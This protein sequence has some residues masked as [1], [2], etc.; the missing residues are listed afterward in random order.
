VTG[1]PARRGWYPLAAVA[2]LVVA[3]TFATIG[4]GVEVRE[5]AGARLLIVDWGHTLVWVLLTLSFAAAALRG[6]GDAWA[7]G[8][9]IGAAVAYGAFLVAV[10]TRPAHVPGAALVASATLAALAGLQVAVALGAPWGRL[11]WGGAHRVL[12]TRLRVASAASALL[13][14]G[15]AW[16][17]LRR[18]GVLPGAVDGLV[19]VATWALCGYF[20]LG[21]VLNLASRSRAERRTMVPASSLLAAASLAI[22]LT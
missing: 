4:D 7:N 20:T 13:Y 8:L 1:R 6:G 22:A 9:A 16:V 10:F 2:A 12:P 14:A 19:A 3:I 15:F 21:I 18:A 17:L 5:A 11:V